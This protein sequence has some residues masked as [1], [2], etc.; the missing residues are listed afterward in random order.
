MHRKKRH[1]RISL[2][3]YFDDTISV[4]FRYN[5]EEQYIGSIEDKKSKYEKL[6]SINGKQKNTKNQNHVSAHIPNNYL[7][8][9][10]EFQKSL[11]IKSRISNNNNG[12]NKFGSLASDLNDDLVSSKFAITNNP[13]S[14]E[15][16]LEDSFSSLKS[17]SYYLSDDDSFDFNEMNEFYIYNHDI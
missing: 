12:I 6:R 5:K 17:C 7:N 16:N 1:Y 10:L 2:I 15:L 13:N 4:C 11:H 14:N 8:V 9:L 3:T